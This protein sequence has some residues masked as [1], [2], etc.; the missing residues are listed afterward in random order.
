M[1]DRRARE[2]TPTE[3]SAWRSDLVKRLVPVAISVGFASRLI[4]T[5]WLVG[6]E[7]PSYEE[8]QEIPRLLTA[9]VIVVIG[10]DWYHRDIIRRP[11]E[12]LSRFVLDIIIIMLDLMFLY[13]SSTKGLIIWSLLLAAIFILYVI[14][15]IISIFENPIPFFKNRA[16]NC[17]KA[18][19]LPL[20]LSV[21]YFGAR[22]PTRENRGPII[23]IWWAIYFSMLFAVAYKYGQVLDSDKIAATHL[24]SFS[25]LKSPAMVQALASSVFSLLGILFLVRDGSAKAEDFDWWSYSRIGIII[26]LVMLYVVTTHVIVSMP[27]VVQAEM[28]SSILRW[29]SEW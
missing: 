27:G 9:I 7:C 23:N 22:W 28:P 5:S 19:T 14:W 11:T 25:V 10:W 4:G 24:C 1:N 21:Y 16:P 17:P 12:T 13:A 8:W 3:I 29:L 26:T 15:D 2:P 20:C 6:G 18:K